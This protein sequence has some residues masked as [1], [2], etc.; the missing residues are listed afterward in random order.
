V[1]PPQPPSFSRIVKSEHRERFWF[2]A[3][4]KTYVPS[5]K[6]FITY[7]CIFCPHTDVRGCEKPSRMWA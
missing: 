6:R 4:Q 7:A 1:L 2:L 5:P 3:T